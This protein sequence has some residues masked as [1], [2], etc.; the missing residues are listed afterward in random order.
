MAFSVDNTKNYGSILDLINRHF[1]LM[2]K[3]P[4]P[5]TALYVYNMRYVCFLSIDG[6]ERKPT[7]KNNDN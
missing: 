4:Y 1:E 6:I 7:Q 5:C 3:F 2:T